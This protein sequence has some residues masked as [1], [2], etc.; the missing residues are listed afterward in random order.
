MARAI[1]SGSIAF[2]LVNV[3]VKLYSAIDEQDL[4]FHYVHRKDDSRI[5][6]EKVCKK[7]KRPVPDDEI[8]K[9]FEISK[10]R[11]V[12]VEDEDF[13]AAEGDRYRTIE[14]S[15]FVPYEEIDPIYFE[16]TYYVGPD[17]R[18]EKVYV[19]LRKAME[20]SGLAAVATYV[21]RSKQQL[22][23]LRVRD[24]VIILEK[25]YFVDE[26]RPTEDIEVTGVSVG[27]RELKMAAEL[28]ERFTGRFDIAKYRD[29]YREALLG[30]IKAKDA[31]EDVHVDRRDREPQTDDLLEALRASIDEHKRNGRS[32]NGD[33]AELTKDELQKRAKRAGVAGYS[34]MT[35]RELVRALD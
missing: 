35:K 9:A 20:G 3:P 23:C 25:M 6:Y 31:G 13:E 5:G 8:V 34:R 14:I 30:V 4:R 19:L 7:E 32:K 16:H 2:G 29:E 27:K 26:V 18:A 1:W 28:I 10:G 11:Y 15:D 17:D 22:G 21:M 12:Y 33:R 24:G